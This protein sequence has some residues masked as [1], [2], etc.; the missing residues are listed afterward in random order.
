M[1]RTTICLW[2]GAFVFEPGIFCQNY[3]GID[4][5]AG[6]PTLE[7]FPTG[8][9]NQG[10]I[11]GYYTDTNLL[12]HGFVRSGGGT[13]TP[14]NAPG[15]FVSTFAFSIN[16]AGA[17]TGY[18]QASLPPPTRNHGFVRDSGGNFTSFDPPGSISTI[19]LSINAGGAITG[20]YNEANLAIHGFVREPGGKITSL[21]PPG[22]I[23][24][25]PAGINASGIVTGSYSDTKGTHGFVR[26]LWGTIESFDPPG[27]TGTIVTAINNAETITGYYTVSNGRTF[28]FVRRPEGTF[29]SF[30]VPGSFE[31]TTLP[32]SLLTAASSINDAGAI[33]GSYSDNS[34]SHGF[35]RSPEGMI[36]SFDPPTVTSCSLP[37]AGFAAFTTSINQEGVITGWCVTRAISNFFAGF[38]RFP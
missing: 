25:K 35:V 13:I 32:G 9:N 30:D 5:F 12:H 37:F 21:D 23:S 1:L 7:T 22:S 24:T 14:F 2:L 16:D 17:I 34:G 33:T 26:G 36:T 28:G 8:I 31:I 3:V 6:G 15:P 20:Y 10:E 27:S 38:A 11:T 29:E 19:A 18:F 4:V